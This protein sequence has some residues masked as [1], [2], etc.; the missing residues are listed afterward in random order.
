MRISIRKY[1]LMVYI[2]VT[3]SRPLAAV[4]EPQFPTSLYNGFLRHANQTVVFQYY[5]LISAILPFRSVFII[6][7]SAPDEQNLSRFLCDVQD[8]P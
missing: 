8:A 5:N 7:P 6:G 2:S 1:R 4:A 3:A